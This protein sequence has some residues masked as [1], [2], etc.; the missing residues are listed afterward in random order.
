MRFPFLL[1]A[2]TIWKASAAEK[3]TYIKQLYEIAGSLPP[4]SSGKLL[5]GPDLR[6]RAEWQSWQPWLTVYSVEKVRRLR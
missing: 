2:S 1:F 6:K 4:P 5:K 3:L